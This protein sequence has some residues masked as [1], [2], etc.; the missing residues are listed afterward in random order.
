MRII[1]LCRCIAGPSLFTLSYRHLMQLS[2]NFNSFPELISVN[3][4]FLIGFLFPN[5]YDPL[6]SRLAHMVVCGCWMH[7]CAL[8]ISTECYEIIKQSSRQNDNKEEG[9]GI[10]QEGE[11]LKMRPLYFTIHLL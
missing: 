11:M 1:T 3:V 9:G 6:K 5:C 10:Y 2:D 7:T 8:L 4:S